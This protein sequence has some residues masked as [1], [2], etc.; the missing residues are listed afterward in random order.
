MIVSFD[1]IVYIC[2]RSTLKLQN[3][4][5]P[6]PLYSLIQ[7]NQWQ[8]FQLMEDILLF[9]NKHG[10]EM[11]SSY[12]EKLAKLQAAFD[13]YD[14]VI[15]QETRISA[16]R[17]NELDEQRSYALRKMY[18][19][20]NTYEDFKF[21]PEKQTAS[22]ALL[23]TLKPYGSGRSIARA[24]QPTRTAMTTNMLQDLARET[25]RPHRITLD[26]TILIA[27]LSITNKE[28]VDEQ[29]L[30]LKKEAQKP[31]GVVKSARAKLQKEFL[32][33]VALINALALVEGEQK[34]DVLKKTI[35]AAVKKHVWQAR[36][37]IRKKE[38]GEEETQEKDTT[39]PP[40]ITDMPQEDGTIDEQ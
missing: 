6:I 16:K 2:E 19:V 26:L 15:A 35:G 1:W 20:I 17:Q 13:V 37:R 40:L 36:Q 28:Y 23:H 25:T 32:E 30:R 29:N 34:Y 38:S 33:F 9:A 11:P 8:L 18:Q 12:D 4:T 27:D 10:E 22:R 14:E 24:N 31:T 7:L 3:M 39:H 5:K 21:S